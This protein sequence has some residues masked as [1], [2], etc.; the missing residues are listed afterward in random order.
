MINIA[1]FASGNGTNAQ[2][3]I[4]YFK[5]NDEIRV[6]LILSNK[7]DAF[8]LKRA[9]QAGIPTRTFTPQIL[10]DNA[11]IL[12]YLDQFDV[13][14]I[15]LAGF[16]LL[17]P[18]AIIQ[19]F[20]NRIVNIH[21]ALLP[22]YG[23]KGMYGDNVHKAVIANGETESGITIHYVNEN[24]DDGAIIF[25]ARC[26]VLKVDSSETLAARIHQLEYDHFPRIIND[27]IKRDCC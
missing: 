16:L 3:I 18:T 25:Q 19:R 7:T 15:V 5:G 14:F 12:K 22:A 8:V 26:P 10:R 1:I 17:M 13:N 9:E 24:Y 27:V 4:D 23:G 6:V 2:R 21:P 20:Q 11:E